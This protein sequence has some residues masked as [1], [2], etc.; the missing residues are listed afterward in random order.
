MR[1]TYTI[2]VHLA[3]LLAVAV[4]WFNKK[5]MLWVK[6]RKNWK[7]NLQ[8][9]QRRNRVYWFHAASLGE[10]EQGLPV[11]EAL[12]NSVPGCS[13][14]V[15]FFSPSGYEVRK[16]HKIADLV[17]YLP[18]DTNYNARYLTDLLNPD[19]VFF[20]K[21]EFWHY[22]LKELKK[23]QIPVYLLS[24][25]FRPGQ[26][27]FK[28]YGRWFRENLDAF[29]HL[30]VQNEQ[31]AKLLNSIGIKN[32]SI[33]GDTRFD[34]VVKNS[35]QTRDIPVVREFSAGSVCMVAGSTWPADE[36]LL[37]PFIHE[38]PDH[39]RFIIAP[40]EIGKD[41]INR[42]VKS[43]SKDLILFSEASPERV[44]D[45]KVLIID[46]IGML[47]QIYRYGKIAYI[48]GGF[49]KGIHN[50]LEA[51]VYNIPVIFGPNHHKFK[52]AIELAEA[53]GGF[54]VD[55]ESG[56]R[57]IMSKLISFDG[58]YETAAAKAGDYVRTHAGSTARIMNFLKQDLR[59]DYTEK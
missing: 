48:G 23:R 54:P 10:F 28:W 24:G 22:Y 20:I 9:W 41:H 16:N 11:M 34:R 18:L 25:I 6:G 14:V 57:N 38:A 33:T 46:N 45:K 59:P 36:N 27:F 2:I 56:F 37:I 40:H 13:V 31:S 3:Y 7:Q 47:S 15:S 50:I 55:S 44:K 49:G 43:I 39:I 53:G 58:F 52:E 5:T 35:G 51:A 26:P 29:R 1:F 19:A 4:S 42:I 32:V 12:K 8:K 30:F 21:Y 17:L